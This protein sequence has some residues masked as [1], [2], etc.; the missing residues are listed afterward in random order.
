MVL[1]AGILSGVVAAQEPPPDEIAPGVVIHVVQRGENLFRIALNYGLTVEEIAAANGISNPAS[2][3]VGQRLII[4]L[5]SPPSPSEPLTHVVA[6][7]SRSRVSLP[8]M[9]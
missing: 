9:G 2:I 5:N 4:P 7:V 1:A 3:I 6:L 8:C